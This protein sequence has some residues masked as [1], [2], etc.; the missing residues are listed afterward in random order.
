M[1]RL[2]ID[3]P[4]GL[5]GDMLL[6]A[7]LDLSVPRKV[8]EEPL[9][10]IGL[11]SLYSLRVEEGRSFGLRGLKVSVDSLESDPPQRSWRDIQALILKANFKESLRKRVL[12]VFQSLA[13]AEGCVH[14][15]NVDEVHFHEIGAIDS[16][17]DVVGVCACFEYLSP[18]AV[19]CTTPPAGEGNIQTSH[20][21]LPVPVPAVLELARKNRIILDSSNDFP[22]GELTTPTGLALIAILVNQFSR[23]N[24]LDIKRFGIGLGSRRLDRPNLLRLCEIND[25]DIKDLDPKV[26]LINKQSLIVQEAWIDDSSPEDLAVLG[27]HLRLAGALDVVSEQLQMKKSRH[28]V[29]LRA[30]VREENANQLRMVW[31]SKGTV[32]GLREYPVNRWSLP[33]RAGFYSTSFGKVRVKQ[34]RRPDGKI[35]FKFENDDLLRISLE[36][37]L[38]VDELRVQLRKSLKN[39]IPSGGWSW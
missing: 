24:V 1:S 39:F 5:S 38:S 27:D 31:F 30:L 28:G 17:V 9:A 34:A 26:G 14:G 16:L 19:F 36:Q 37:G 15:L 12:Q 32:L 22:A 11:E 8:I 2:F 29:C 6:G 20:G 7:C 18:S 21:I 3:C 25:E 35:S 10:A 23:P 4:T 13:D 33:R